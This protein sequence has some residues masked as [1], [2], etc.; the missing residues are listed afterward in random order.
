LLESL[1]TEKVYGAEPPLTEMLQPA[2]ATPWVPPGQ[3]V[4]VIVNGP[5]APAGVTVTD[6]VA[7]VVP[8]T[9]VADSV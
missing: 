6:A 8:E 7:V 9:F 4:V 2:Y 1:L 5:P 3:E